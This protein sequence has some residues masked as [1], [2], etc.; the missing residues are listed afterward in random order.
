[1]VRLCV[2]CT[3]ELKLELEQ[4]A[5]CRIQKDNN[6]KRGE[7]MSMKRCC[8]PNSKWLNL[9]SINKNSK[10]WGLADTAQSGGR[11]LNI[12]GKGVAGL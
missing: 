4:N 7:T 1:M 2:L 6:R 10:I 12:I 8:G 9:E 3:L 11:E 5:E